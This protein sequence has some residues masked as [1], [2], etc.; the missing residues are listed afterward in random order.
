MIKIDKTYIVHFEGLKDRKSYIDN[1]IINKQKVGFDNF[2]YIISS[3]DSDREILK[4]TNYVYNSD[5]WTSK[6]SDVE[7][8][9]Y[10][11]QK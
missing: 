2:E 3:V 11:V 8:C 1:E 9:N 5:R 4:N 6:L 7:I 10:E